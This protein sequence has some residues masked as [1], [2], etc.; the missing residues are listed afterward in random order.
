M[1][2]NL[3]KKM[4]E[5]KYLRLNDLSSYKIAFHL[6]NHIWEIVCKWDYFAQKTI[7][8]QFVDAIDSVAANIAEGFGAHS[9]KDRIKFYRYA[10]RSTMESL[11]WNEKARRRKLIDEKQYKYIFQELKKLPRE[12]NNLISYTN[13]KLA[14]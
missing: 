14:I 6:S 12:I 3:C 5:K 13:K 8:A 2:S 10:R 7:G 1:P 9:K 11:D 4:G